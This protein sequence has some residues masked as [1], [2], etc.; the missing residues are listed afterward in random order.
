VIIA[1]VVLWP[2][3]T[4]SHDPAGTSKCPAGDGKAGERKGRSD[5]ELK[6]GENRVPNWGL[7]WSYPLPCLCEAK[8]TDHRL[9]V[10]QY[11]FELEM[12]SALNTTHVE[13]LPLFVKREKF[14]E[15]WHDSSSRTESCYCHDSLRT[16]ASLEKKIVQEEQ[17][18]RGRDPEGRP[19]V[20]RV[21]NELFFL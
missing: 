14:P 2:L 4:K 18:R 12:L 16:A 9:S 19:P 11:G 1:R 7:P 8:D 10:I 5:W 3:T 17:L 13:S 20:P 21:F 6:K 15:V